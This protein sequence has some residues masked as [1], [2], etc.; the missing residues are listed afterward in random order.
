M[1]DVLFD[2]SSCNGEFGELINLLEVLGSFI[3]DVVIFNSGLDGGSTAH[4]CRLVDDAEGGKAKWKKGGGGG[5]GKGERE[6]PVEYEMGVFILQRNVM[7]ILVSLR[8]VAFGFRRTWSS[9]WL[10]G[11][12]QPH[13]QC[14]HNA[15]Y[16][17]P[18]SQP[19]RRT[20]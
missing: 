6:K 14:A 17:V 12:A 8:R 10:Y 4:C 16:T 7:F 20:R 2:V 11:L 9:D 5:G 15:M 13:W 3:N 1:R 18:R 19:S